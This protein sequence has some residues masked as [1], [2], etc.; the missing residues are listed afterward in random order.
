MKTGQK[1]VTN[2][3]VQNNSK[4]NKKKQ[5]KTSDLPPEYT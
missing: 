1:N 3:V 4:N 2:K 5:N